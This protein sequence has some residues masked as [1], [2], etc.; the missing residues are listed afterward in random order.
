MSTLR[1]AAYNTIVLYLGKV[2]GI[3]I[4][5][6][7]LAFTT[8][9]LGVS[10]FG[11]YSTVLSI[12][13]ILVS[14]TELGLNWIVSREL[15]QGNTGI[16][17]SLT[18]FKLL[19]TASCMG[20][21]ALVLPFI[22]YNSNIEKGVWL[23]A[24]YIFFGSINNLQ[25]A[26][27]QGT[28]NL[29]KTAYTDIASRLVNLVL[30]IIVVKGGLGYFWAVA[31]LNGAGITTL[32]LNNYFIRKLK[33]P[34]YRFDLSGLGA[35]RKELLEMAILSAVTFLVY[36]TDILILARLKSST[37][38]GIYG[39]AYRILDVAMTVPSILIGALYPVLSSLYLRRTEKESVSVFQSAFLAVIL[40]G[41]L[42]TALGILTAPVTL[43]VLAGTSFVTAS[44]VSWFG[45]PVTSILILQV[46][47]VFLLFSFV[48]S[49]ANAL[50]IIAKKQRLCLWI[51]AFGLVFNIAGNILFIPAHS[52]LACALLTV[53]TQVVITIPL[54]WGLY[55]E[56]V[57]M[58]GLI[59]L[60]RVLGVTVI[61]GLLSSFVYSASPL[62]AAALF[63]V[64][65]MILLYAAGG[66]PKQLAGQL[67]A[68][69]QGS[70]LKA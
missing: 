29:D 3:L 36:K 10:L 27:L 9:Y 19:L 68:R 60:V 17:N 38:V 23:A 6:A 28:S 2:A 54:M 16:L 42:T 8:R 65:W 59:D 31:A 44:T 49:Y 48:S 20:L 64:M 7:T 40:I 18:N 5:A 58:V 55:V 32:L 67:L 69:K 35:Y 22:G 30:I 4:S 61:A 51:N 12:S 24:L 50:L 70:L 13:A 34:S 66:R 26:V 52:Y 21:A 57:S 11:D 47:S 53:I 14:L 25:I 63:V 46:L 1:R 39:A 37:D 62:G 15:A 45:H 41:C 33:L 56:R 43:R